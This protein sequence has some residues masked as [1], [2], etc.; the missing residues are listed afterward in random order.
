VKRERKLVNTLLGDNL[1]HKLLKLGTLLI[2]VIV[3]LICDLKIQTNFF[4]PA[5]VAGFLTM[6]FM[7]Y[8]N[9]DRARKFD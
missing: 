7:I 6:A 9:I 4:V 3:A 1:I 2:P 5:F 8:H